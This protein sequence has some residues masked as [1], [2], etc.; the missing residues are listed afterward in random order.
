LP[1]PPVQAAL[2]LLSYAF[3]LNTVFEKEF[4]K[5]KQTAMN[6]GFIKTLYNLS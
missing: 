2:S 5:T 1:G 4:I 3:S 6:T